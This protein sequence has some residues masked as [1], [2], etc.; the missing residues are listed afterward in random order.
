MYFDVGGK[1]I[2]FDAYSFNLVVC[3]YGLSEPEI[4][5]CR[6]GYCSDPEASRRIYRSMANKI[7]TDY[8]H[9][10]GKRV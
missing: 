7:L 9:G 10:V 2:P 4:D 5:N 1:M 6:M 8:A 3:H